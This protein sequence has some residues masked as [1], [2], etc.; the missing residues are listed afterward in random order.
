MNPGRV[1]SPAATR[2]VA[3][4][5]SVTQASDAARSLEFVKTNVSPVP[6]STLAERANAAP[7]ASPATQSRTPFH[8]SLF[9][10]NPFRSSLPQ[11]NLP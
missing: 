5:A 1:A 9:M 7:H 10:S 8:L 4:S 3:P 11:K 6:T 2:N